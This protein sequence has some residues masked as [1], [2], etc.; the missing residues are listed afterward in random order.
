MKLNL[1]ALGRQEAR[2]VGIAAVVCAG[3]WLGAG[4]GG[5]AMEGCRADEEPCVSDL[6]AGGTDSTSAGSGGAPGSGGTAGG[7]GGGAGAGDGGAGP[8]AGG[9]TGGGLAPVAPGDFGCEPGL[10]VAMPLRLLNRHYDST[11]RDLLGITGLDAHDGSPPSSLLATD[12]VGPLTE[13]A[14]AGYQAAAEA[15]AAQ[16]LSGPERASFIDCD[17]EDE[18]CLSETIEVFGRKAFRRPLSPGEV[19]ELALL[20]PSELQGQ[21][22]AV[23][24]DILT[25]I[26]VSPHFIEREIGSGPIASDGSFELTSHE[27]ATRL[28]Y[29]VLGSTPDA[30][31]SEA[32]DL[33]QLE[34]P[35]QVRA[36]VERMLASPLASEGV[37]EVHKHYLNRYPYYHWFAVE[38]DTAAYPNFTPDVPPAAEEELDTFFDSIAFS[39]G[40]FS[41][42]FL[43]PNGFVNAAL[44]PIYGLDP[45]AFGDALVATPLDPT[46]RPGFLTRVAFLSSFSSYQTT[47][48]ILRGTFIGVSILGLPIPPPEPDLG[49][50]IPEGDFTTN[51]ERTEALTSQKPCVGCHEQ[52]INPPGFVLEHYDAI[53]SWQ[54]V[55]PAGGAIDPVADVFLGDRVETIETPLELMQAL[56]ASE[57]ARRQ[58]VDR[59]VSFAF[60]RQP[61]AADA[62]LSEELMTLIEDDATPLLDLWPALAAHESF[63]RGARPD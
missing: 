4:C 29:F 35:E 8:G 42:L 9:G 7:T 25:A 15:I 16:V 41:D 34:T 26:L 10:V 18:A 63:R 1:F 49:L 58:Y 30:E 11:V 47:S 32:A 54:V 5:K 36:Q 27:L 2:R 19:D 22:D 39:G 3:S 13:V 23:A 14:I 6:G 45:S 31:L 46:E 52:Y 24:A 44:A 56:A 57:H 43:S 50:P 17:A 59:L 21:G 55:D 51:R 37:G 12:S 33:G 61:N 28:S 60:E 62:C 40:T 48:P 53:G 38:H 20:I